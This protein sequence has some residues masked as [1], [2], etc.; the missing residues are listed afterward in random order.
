MIGIRTKPADCANI[1][2]LGMTLIAQ[3]A[4]EFFSFH[5]CQASVVD[6]L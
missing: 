2:L 3:V 1:T 4:C 6:L 5:A